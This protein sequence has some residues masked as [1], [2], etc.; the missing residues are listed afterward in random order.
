MSSEY[1]IYAELSVWFK[2]WSQNTSSEFK[3][4]AN[5][6]EYFKISPICTDTYQMTWSRGVKTLAWATTVYWVHHILPSYYQDCNSTEQR[7]FLRSSS[8]L[9]E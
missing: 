4:Y 3:M 5:L 6:G 8:S 1:K 9:F 7:F 2:I